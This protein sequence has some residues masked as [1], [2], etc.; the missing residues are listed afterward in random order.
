MEN[1]KISNFRK[2]KDTWDLDLSPVTFFTGTNNSGKSTVFKALLVLEDYINS[3]NHFELNLN[4]NNLFKHKIESYSNAIN[5]FNFQESRKDVIFK[6]KNKGYDISIKFEPDVNSIKA[7]LQE[8][9]ILR[10]DTA[11]LEINRMGSNTYKLQVDAHF[12]NQSFIIEEKNRIEINKFHKIERALASIIESNESKLKKLESETLYLVKKLERIIFQKNQNSTSKI[13]K[14][15]DSDKYSINNV[16]QLNR[17]KI[18]DLKKS[19]YDAEIKQKKALDLFKKKFHSRKDNLT[20][21]PTFSLEDFDIENRG[22]DKIIR[23]VL[24]KYL[25]ETTFNATKGN[26]FK[27]SDKSLEL[28]KANKL[29]DEILSAIT[30]KIKHL[31]PHRSSQNKLFVHDDKGVDINNLVK[32]HTEKQSYPREEVLIFMKNWMSKENFDIGEDYRIETYESLV[33][34]I[35]ILEDGTWINISDKGFGAGQVFSIL[36][37]IALSILDIIENNSTK[38]RYNTIIIIEE[39]EANLHPALQSKLADLF[40]EVYEEFGIR[41]ILET[42]SEY[43]IRQSQYLNMKSRTTGTSNNMFGLY[44]FQ[45]DGDPY[46]MYYL[47]NGKFDRPF[48]SGFFNVADDLAVDMYKASLKK[49]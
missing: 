29:G 40:Y 8:L 34:K 26:N 35:E 38:V 46:P 21:N 42:H 16:I 27:N 22:I 9:K 36:L 25:V 41:F 28:N 4:R 11:T 10:E 39:P 14:T 17:K 24:P 18:L 44:Y 3:K 47:E 31:S 12:F 23:S 5:R 6:F 33:S 37:A 30:F 1:I 19:T 49:N 2:I 48:G 15:L 20:Y 43:L 13:D 32:N 7:N 45:N